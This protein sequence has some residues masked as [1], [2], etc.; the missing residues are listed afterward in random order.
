LRT[1]IIKYERININNDAEGYKDS[2]TGIGGSLIQNR[3]IRKRK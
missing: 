2:S 1:L 3:T